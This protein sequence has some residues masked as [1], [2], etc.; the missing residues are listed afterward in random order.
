MFSIFLFYFI[1]FT[2]KGKKKKEKEKEKERHVLKM[3]TQLK[4]FNVHSSFIF[5]LVYRLFSLFFLPE[6]DNISF[7][8]IARCSSK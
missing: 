7:S 6:I 1:L 4:L 8:T 2:Q 3:F 5:N